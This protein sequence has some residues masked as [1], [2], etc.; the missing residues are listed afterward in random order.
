MRDEVQLQLPALA[1][2]GTYRLRWY[3]A[4]GRLLVQERSSGGTTIQPVLN[5]TAGIY[6]LRVNTERGSQTVKLVKW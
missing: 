2:T 4:Q 6:Y 3:D 1:S 5:W